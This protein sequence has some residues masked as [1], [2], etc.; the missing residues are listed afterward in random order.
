SW[1]HNMAGEALERHTE[2][3]IEVIHTLLK[4]G[5]NQDLYR[6]V[7]LKNSAVLKVYFSEDLASTVCKKTTFFHQHSSRVKELNAALKSS[8]IK[9]IKNSTIVSF[10]TRHGIIEMECISEITKSNN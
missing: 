2:N 6:E 4:I 3:L 8:E 5:A 10:E 9:R 1:M 7:N